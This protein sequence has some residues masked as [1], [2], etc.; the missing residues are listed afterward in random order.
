RK[1]TYDVVPGL[2]DGEV[3]GFDVPVFF[4]LGRHDFNTPSQLASKYMDRLDAP[5]KGIVW[6][7]HSAHFPFFEEPGRFHDEMVRVD[8]AVDA[9]WMDRSVP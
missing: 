3:A 7:E 4:F 2:W 1:M 5:L 6:F 9:F 8:R